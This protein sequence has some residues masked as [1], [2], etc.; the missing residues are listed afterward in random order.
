[1]FKTNFS[2]H[3]K[4]WG[5]QKKLGGELPS[6]AFRGYGPGTTICNNCH[7]CAHPRTR[8]IKTYNKVQKPILEH[9]SGLCFTH[10]CTLLL[11]HFLLSSQRCRPSLS[12]TQSMSFG[13]SFM[14]LVKWKRFCNRLVSVKNFRIKKISNGEKPWEH[15]IS[16]L[17]DLNAQKSKITR[18]LR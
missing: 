10:P 8:C 9:F 6:N 15:F 2:G 14:I 4:I 7:Y 5:E 13:W 1:M 18:L 11:H 12:T 3:N 17:H 16:I